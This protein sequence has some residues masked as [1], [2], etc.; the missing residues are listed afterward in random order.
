[1]EYKFTLYEKEAGIAKSTLNRPE[2]MNAILRPMIAEVEDQLEDFTEDKEAKVWIITGAGR[3]FC[4]GDDLDELKKLHGASGEMRMPRRA[5]RIPRLLQ[6][7]DKPT[8]AMVNG[9]AIGM[10]FEMAL[11]CDFIIA[12]EKARFGEVYV[13]RGTLPSSGP[14][15]LPRKIGLKNAIEIALLGEL[16]GAEQAERYGLTYKVVPHEQLE[17]AT[18]ELAKK[19]A[20][21]PPIAYQFTKHALIRGL[22]WNL[23]TELDYIA[24]AR[25]VASKAGEAVA[26]ITAFQKQMSK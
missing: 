18:M 20:N 7:I 2:K 1:M 10:G 3:G 21:L 6:A 12:S 13:Q 15:L 5:A 23:D 24:Y 16:F 8:I 4:A 25:E 19:L 22:D 17:A 9:A 11:A 26:A 14:W